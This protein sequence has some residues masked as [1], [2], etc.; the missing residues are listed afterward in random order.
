MPDAIIFRSTHP[1]VLQAWDDW[2][3]GRRSSADALKAL[4]SQ[5]DPDGNE[6]E[7]LAYAATGT[8]PA[9]AVGLKAL[10]Q[11]REAPPTGWRHID[12]GRGLD[13]CFILPYRRSKQGKEIYELIKA[14]QQPQLDIPGMP[15]ESWV[16]RGA[17]HGA[18]AVLSPGIAVI[19]RVVYAKWAGDADLSADRSMS[20]RRTVDPS[21][22]EPCPLSEFYAATERASVDV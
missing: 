7:V 13:H 1:D 9:T 6:R 11:D 14:W 16:Y 8:W 10:P 15:R 17:P 20:D 2:V 4:A 3:A 21:M 18:M 5:I 22:W 19:D 12:P